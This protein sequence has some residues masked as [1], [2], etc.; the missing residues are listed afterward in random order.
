MEMTRIQPLRDLMV[1]VLDEP[2]KTT[3][4]GIFMAKAWEDAVNTA[5]IVAVGPDVKQCRIGEH[6]LINPYAYID[7]T[8]ISEKLIKEGDVLGY[9]R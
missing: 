5:H 3:A 1:I 7:L 4:S 6:I 8:G 2:R 9:V